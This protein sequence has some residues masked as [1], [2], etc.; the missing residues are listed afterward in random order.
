MCR[1]KKLPNRQRSVLSSVGRAL[2]DPASKDQKLKSE[3]KN[4]RHYFHFILAAPV[5][6]EM[7]L[8]SYRFAEKSVV[9][10]SDQRG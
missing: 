10:S 5:V 4:Q 1:E 6:R 8:D 9:M 2:E 7:M 3:K